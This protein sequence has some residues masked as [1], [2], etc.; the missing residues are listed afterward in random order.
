MHYCNALLHHVAMHM[1]HAYYTLS[2]LLTASSSC[3]YILPGKSSW[4]G[5]LAGL[6]EAAVEKL[7]LCR[8]PL[9]VRYRE[10]QMLSL[11]FVSSYIH[12]GVCIACSGCLP[13]TG[14]LDQQTA[15]PVH[16]YGSLEQMLSWSCLSPIILCYCCYRNSLSFYKIF[17]LHCGDK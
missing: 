12:L 2:H 9:W 16:I 4:S 5:L 6:L 14:Q 1:L 3:W 17:C 7:V 13:P 11:T 10:R 8:V 15:I